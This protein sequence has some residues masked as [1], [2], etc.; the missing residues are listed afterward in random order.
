[1]SI[2]LRFSLQALPVQTLFR[3]SLKGFV[4][5]LEP[6]AKTLLGYEHR[7]K[8]GEENELKKRQQQE[9]LQCIMRC[10]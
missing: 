5:P 6:R 4:K 1:M 10:K 2:K 9:K 7:A 3:E 8:E